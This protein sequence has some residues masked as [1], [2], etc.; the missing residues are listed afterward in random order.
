MF[1]PAGPVFMVLGVLL[2][3]AG[4]RRLRSSRELRQDWLAR[5]LG[6]RKDPPWQTVRNTGLVHIAI[7]TAAFL[8]G[9]WISL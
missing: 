9:L 8:L 3:E 1:N 6:V 2:L 5:K 7:G 4:T